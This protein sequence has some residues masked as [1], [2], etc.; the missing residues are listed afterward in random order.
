MPSASPL[1]PV[2]GLPQHHTTAEELRLASLLATARGG[3]SFAALSRASDDAMATYAAL[4]ALLTR[5]TVVT[6][7]LPGGEVG[8]RRRTRR[9][10]ATAVAGEQHALRLAA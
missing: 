10:G 4:F 6:T 2:L 9:R 7:E 1:T 5:G 3:L 8:Y